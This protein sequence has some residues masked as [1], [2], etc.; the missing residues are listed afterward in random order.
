MHTQT[1]QWFLVMIALALAIAPL[2]GGWATSTLA[3][4]GS[5]S[6]CD[7]MDMQAA[8]TQTGMQQQVGADEA[9]DKCKQGCNGSCCD[10]LCNACTQS[11][12]TLPASVFSTPHL[13]D[14]LLDIMV[15]TSFTKRTVIPPLRP[16]ASL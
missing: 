7:Q 12:S 8:D 1:Q 5:T 13:H 2:R 6:H 4:S 15:L 3:N 11:P 10:S 14:T 9:G 16:P